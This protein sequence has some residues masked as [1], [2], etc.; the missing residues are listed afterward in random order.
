MD[1]QKITVKTRLVEIILTNG[2]TVKGETFLQLH[3]LQQDGLQRVGEVLNSDDD[4]LPVRND[5]GCN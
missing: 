1:S 5:E 3:G 4:F 2:S